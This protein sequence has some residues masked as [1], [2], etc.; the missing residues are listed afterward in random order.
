MK[1]ALLLILATVLI[2]GKKAKS[3]SDQNGE[4]TAYAEQCAQGAIGG[5]FLM[6]SKR[7]SEWQ[8]YGQS[9]ESQSYLCRLL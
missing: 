8:Q 6:V 1:L 2:Q 7:H 5:T 3:Q 9:D 4:E